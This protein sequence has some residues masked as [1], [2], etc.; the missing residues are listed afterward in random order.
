MIAANTKTAPGLPAARLTTCQSAPSARDRE[1]EG[2]RTLQ[3]VVAEP[4]RRQRTNHR[5]TLYH[6]RGTGYGQPLPPPQHREEED[7]RQ[8]LRRRSQ[9]PS[10]AREA[11][12]GAQPH[13][14]ALAQ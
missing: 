14:G 3:E 13:S 12:A 10:G 1:A 2:R 4:A 11:A 7:D 8:E 5:V 9:T 6:N